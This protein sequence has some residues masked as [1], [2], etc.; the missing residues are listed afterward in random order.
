MRVSRLEALYSKIKLRIHCWLHEI[1]YQNVAKWAEEHGKRITLDDIGIDIFYLSEEMPSRISKYR[2][3]LYGFADF[4]YIDES[5]C[6]AA[7]CAWNDK[8]DLRQI[9]RKYSRFGHWENPISCALSD[10][11]EAEV[12][13]LARAAYKKDQNSGKS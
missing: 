7:L 8:L 4:V 10:L 2:V 1:D 3:F 5:P 13:E 9:D 6:G 11:R 12:I